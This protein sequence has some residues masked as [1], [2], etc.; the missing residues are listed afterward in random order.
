MLAHAGNFQKIE[1]LWP[2][3]IFISTYLRYTEKYCPYLEDRETAS[4]KE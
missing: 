2:Y 1:Q 4:W 3:L